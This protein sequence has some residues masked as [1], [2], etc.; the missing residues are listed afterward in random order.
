MPIELER[1]YTVAEVAK[2]WSF[3]K[4]KTRLL[5]MNEPNVLKIGFD[6][7]RFKRGYHSIRIPESVVR[8][9]HRRLRNRAC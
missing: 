1:H 3:S 8:A 4:E 9:V 7:T 2:M 6:E 5:F